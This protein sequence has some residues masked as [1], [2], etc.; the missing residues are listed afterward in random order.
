[1]GKN[2]NGKQKQTL[3]EVPELDEGEEFYDYSAEEGSE[4]YPGLGRRLAVRVQLIG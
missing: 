1:M 2:K 3:E 4:D